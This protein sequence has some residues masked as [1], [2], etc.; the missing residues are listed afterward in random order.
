VAELAEVQA[1]HRVSELDPTSTLVWHVGPELLLR[2]A[3]ELEGP[4]VHLGALSAF[5]GH[6]GERV[7]GEGTYY[8]AAT[9]ELEAADAILQGHLA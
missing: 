5:V 9:R 7:L 4:H 8:Y 1:H 6:G 3:H 2:R